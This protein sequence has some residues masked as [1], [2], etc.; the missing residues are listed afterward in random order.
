VQRSPL[1][2]A[3]CVSAVAGLLAWEVWAR[4]DA[5]PATTQG[6]A[7]PA[8]Q[9]G[10]TTRPPADTTTPTPGP[11]AA[12][13]AGPAVTKLSVLQTRLGPVVVGPGGLTVY[14]F[15]RD[16]ANPPKS[17]CNGGCAAAWPPLLGNPATVAVTK[18]DKS[19]LGSVTRVDGSK[20]LTLKGWPLYFFVDDKKPRD[21]RGEGADGVWH[22]IAPTGKP[23]AA[24]ANNSGGGYGG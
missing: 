2:P 16:T 9:A 20:Q 18:F 11:T 1:I 24:P 3:I 15:D 21:L 19:L 6:K 14:R 17:N 8:A 22:A 13:P 5:H 23:A 10:A 4:T 12:S 7:T